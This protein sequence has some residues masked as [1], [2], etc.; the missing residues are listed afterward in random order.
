M[1]WTMN[2]IKQLKAQ[3]KIIDYQVR[4]LSEDYCPQQGGGSST[5]GSK[6]NKYGAKK[7]V[8]DDIQF[9]SQKEA[10]RYIQLRYMMRSG[11]ISDLRL[12]VPYE[13]NAG[14]THSLQYIADFVYLENGAEIVEDAK[15]FRTKEYRKKRRLMKEVHG[16]QIKET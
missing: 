3:G 12:Q 1:K 14:G 7:V 10:N 8:V 9:D 6:K 13:L 5:K 4:T 15:G 11:L 16:I 2:D